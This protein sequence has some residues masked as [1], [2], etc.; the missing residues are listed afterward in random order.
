MTHRVSKRP[1]RIEKLKVLGSFRPSKTCLKSWPTLQSTALT[2]NL[3]IVL[4]K[5]YLDVGEKISGLKV[6]VVEIRP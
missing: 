1:I 4:K 2:K 6:N 3:F 5:K